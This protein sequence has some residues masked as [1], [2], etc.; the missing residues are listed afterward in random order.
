MPS[1]RTERTRRS[2]LR[3]LGGLLFRLIV[4]LSSVS[5]I[6]LLVLALALNQILNTYFEQQEG[7]RLMQAADGAANAMAQVLS[8]AP[9][10]VLGLPEVREG[11]LIPRL[12]QLVADQVPSTVEVSNPD[13][14]VFARAEP[15]NTDALADQGL[16]ADP[17]VPA[18]RRSFPVQLPAP[19]QP[20]TGPDGVLRLTV[21]LSEPFTSR[22]QALDSVRGALLG[23]SLLALTVSVVV[24]MMAARRLTGPLARLRGAS[25]RLAQGDLDERVPPSGIREFD[26]L[27]DQFNVMADRLRESLTL[28][29]ADRDRLREFVADV[30]HELRTPIAALRT[31]TELQRDGELDPAIRGEFLARSAEQIGRLEWLSSNLLDLSRIEAG[32]LPLDMRPGDLRDPIRSTVEAH[33]TVAEAR[34]ISLTAELPGAPVTLTFDRQRIVQLVT[35]LLGNAL[36]FTPQGGAVSVRLSGA[37]EGAVIEA[38]DTGPGIPADE[39]PRIFER[40]YRGTNVGEAR[41]V[42]SGLGLAIARSIA[43]MHRGRIEVESIVGQGS[44]FRVLLPHNEPGSP[45]ATTSSEKI[46]ET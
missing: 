46:N 27:A 8:L 22:R 10:D 44:V 17:L 13:G 37:D 23:A 20:L 9:D 30:S 38:R 43:E 32:I 18:Q 12:T 16:A 1:P 2:P 25:A 21:E 33:A 39:L 42:G 11:S 45:V 3:L 7:R 26:Q 5:L 19:E 35:N 40:F 34:N 4:V 29:S 28:L 36:K 41:G 14:S 31:F 6:A 24:G 15:S